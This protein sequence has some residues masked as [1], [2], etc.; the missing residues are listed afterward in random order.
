MSVNIFLPQVTRIPI[1]GPA[2]Y[3]T[4]V[5]VSVETYLGPQELREEQLSR[6]PMRVAT[7][8]R[9]AG[10]D[11]RV[12][13]TFDHSTTAWISS[14]GPMEDG[15]W[16]YAVDSVAGAGFTPTDGAYYLDL[17]A[18]SSPDGSAP[19]TCIAF[20]EGVGIC[21]Y[22]VRI[23]ATSW[24]LCYEPPI[25]PPPQGHIHRLNDLVR[26]GISPANL[27]CIPTQSPGR[28]AA[29]DHTLRILQQFGIP[30]SMSMSGAGNVT[31]GS[32]C[33]CTSSGYSTCGSGSGGTVSVV[34]SDKKKRRGG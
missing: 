29:A 14:I 33:V 10:F 18:A 30:I 12:P 32:R 15:N 21:F 27:A 16:V 9:L 2:P 4:L 5:C 7:P 28:T 22:F 13:P 20:A 31:S 6:F 26:Q 1:T 23:Q 34:L 3:N 17:M 11:Q 8:F 24:V 19:G 25:V